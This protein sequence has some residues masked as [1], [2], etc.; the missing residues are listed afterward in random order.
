[1]AQ[2]EVNDALNAELEEFDKRATG[3]VY[4]C[5][6]SNFQGSCTNYGVTLG[7]CSDLPSSFNDNI[8]SFGPDNGLRCCLY[9]YAEFSSF[10]FFTGISI[11]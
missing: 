2:A 5:T 11:I 6:D 3:H 7:S 9:E 8:S 4:L 1:L 10:F